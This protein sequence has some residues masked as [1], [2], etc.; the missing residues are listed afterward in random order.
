[1][2]FSHFAGKAADGS[3][4]N[5]EKTFHIHTSGVLNARII[6]RAKMNIKR[7]SLLETGRW[8]GIKMLLGA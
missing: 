3:Q 5:K 8:S 1:M 4:N 6:L 2:Y 7:L